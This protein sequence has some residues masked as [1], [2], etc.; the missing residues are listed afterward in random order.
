ML[1]PVGC[2]WLVFLL[3]RYK[4]LF[5][6]LKKIKFD[7]ISCSTMVSMHKVEPPCTYK[8]NMNLILS[9]LLYFVRRVYKSKQN[10][11]SILNNEES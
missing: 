11:F 4:N 9:T 5:L 1:A 6:E 8:K 10:T 3:C 2:H 7:K